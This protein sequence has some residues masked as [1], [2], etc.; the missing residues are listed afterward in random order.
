[1]LSR[2]L[3]SVAASL[4][5]IIVDFDEPRS[6]SSARVVDK[7]SGVKGNLNFRGSAGF[8]LAGLGMGDEA[9][10]QSRSPLLPIF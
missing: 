7:Q 4:L 10:R 5:I 3:E 8:L 9:L 6:S 1:M 2:N